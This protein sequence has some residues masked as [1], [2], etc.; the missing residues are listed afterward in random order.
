[1]TGH[2][3]FLIGCGVEIGAGLACDVSPLT[4]FVVTGFYDGATEGFAR[5]KN[6]AT[7]IHFRIVWWDD[8]QDNRLFEGTLVPIEEIAHA[9]ELFAFYERK[10]GIADWS[11][12]L[13]DEDMRLAQELERL[14]SSSRHRVRVSI[15]CRSI[16]EE[17]FL[18]P[19]LNEGENDMPSE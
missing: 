7:L 18:L 6:A 3:K 15:L 5:A 13:S 8:Q 14:L 10:T 11:E 9:K 12:P 1:M 17:I 2:V 16:T 4:G 19:E